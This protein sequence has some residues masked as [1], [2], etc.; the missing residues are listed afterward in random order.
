M[1]C[2]VAISDGVNVYMGSDSAISDSDTGNMS[3]LRL[4]KIFIRDEYLIGYSGSIRFGK[5]IQHSFEFPIV[6][7]WAVGSDKLD[8]FINGSVIP[9]MKIQ[10][11]SHE[12]EP[13]EKE[14]FSLLIGIRGHIFEVDNEWGAYE[15]L[16]NYAAIGSGGPIALGAIY[17]SNAIGS[18]ESKL[19]LG[20][21]SAIKFNAFC[22]EPYTIYK[23]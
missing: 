10:T 20:L 15:V 11:S 7:E 9:E 16:D 8:E 2:V 5:F 18:P 3:N 13:K 19:I 17:A 21:K 12:L 6:P 14:V 23:I 1:T 22:K 4:P